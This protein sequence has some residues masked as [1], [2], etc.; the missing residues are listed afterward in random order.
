[1]CSCVIFSLAGEKSPRSSVLSQ[2]S[3]EKKSGGGMLV[4]P[5]AAPL[6]TS[7]LNKLSPQDATERLISS[8]I[9][10]RGADEGGLDGSAVSPVSGPV[11]I[12]A[13]RSSRISSRQSST[14]S[15]AKLRALRDDDS[16]ADEEGGGAEAG[17]PPLHSAQKVGLA[18]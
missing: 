17:V 1:M 18:G 3:L 11:P 15:F 16:S 8:A 12:P 2:A 5:A 9:G 13:F 4:T 7:K 6:S 14:S 10:A